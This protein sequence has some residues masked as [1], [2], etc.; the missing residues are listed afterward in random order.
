MTTV[1][2]P[3]AAEPIIP[4]WN[5]PAPHQ[6]GNGPDDIPTLTV[7]L[8]EKGT[9][10]LSAILICP[11]GGYGMLASEHEGSNEAKWFAERDVAAFVL[12][13]RLPVHGYL[14][15]VPLLD[16]QRAIRLI[17]SQATEWKINP[18]KVG[19]M[20]FSAGGHLASTLE[21]HDD[22]GDPHAA[23]P[24]DRLSCRPDFA[25]LIYPVITFTGPNAHLG[26]AHNLLGPHP[27]PALLENLSNQDQVTAQTPPTILVHAKDDKAVPFANSEMMLAAL[28]KAGVP[29]TLLVYDHGGHGFGFGHNQ[30]NNN[31]PKD[32]LDRVYAW[33]K[34]QSFVP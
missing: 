31:G 6:K 21:T 4:L 5:G 14:H 17:R 19:V 30:Y 10:P 25:A 8:P 24:V 16:A 32:W 3:A 20:G 34:G 26:S 7:F 23:D 15:P 2:S 18:D 12:K 33:L 28:Q 27:D 1:L 11:G 22:A 9:P 29:C 13:Y